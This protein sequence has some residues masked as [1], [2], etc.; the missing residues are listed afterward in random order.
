MRSSQERHRA[1]TAGERSSAMRAQTITRRNVLKFASLLPLATLIRPRAATVGAPADTFPVSRRYRVTAVVSLFS[2]PLFTRHDAGGAYAAL[3]RSSR[4]TEATLALQ[5]CAGTLPQRVH[6]LNRFGFQQEQ[7]IEQNGEARE[8]AE[9]GFIT[10]C[11][12]NDFEQARN[13]L[14]AAASKL[15]CAVARASYTRDRRV[16][17]LEHFSLPSTYSWANSSEVQDKI[18]AN[19]PA[20]KDPVPGSAPEERPWPFLYAIHRAMISPRQPFQ[21]TFLHN[22]ERSLLETTSHSDPRTGRVLK[23]QGV[24]KD[25]SAVVMLAGFVRSARGQK[26]SEFR[27]WFE[28]GAADAVPLRIEFRPR[29]FL[30]LVFEHDPSTG[31]PQ[32]ASLMSQET[33]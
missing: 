8:S 31:G 2:V 15:G 27:V 4:G 23:A 17:A 10:S 30:H 29:S 21:T 28:S 32:I 19:P 12:E 26:S 6:G 25:E 24:V 33:M 20:L 13:S 18:R 14:F 16:F 9:L 22:A 11:P 7:I 5:F 3:E 1:V